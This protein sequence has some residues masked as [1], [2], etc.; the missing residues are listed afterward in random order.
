MCDGDP[1]GQ[2]DGDPESALVDTGEAYGLQEPRLSVTIDRGPAL[3]EGRI[4]L[5]A[6]RPQTRADLTAHR[7]DRLE[8]GR[9]GGEI[10]GQGCGDDRQVERHAV[11]KMA[12]IGRVAAGARR[13]Q[14]GLDAAPDGRTRSILMGSKD[15]TND[16]DASDAAAMRRKV[17]VASRE[18][19]A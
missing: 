10:G 15:G 6:S 14:A 16:L 18:E 11:G 19:I 1:V 17:W 5:R 2:I 12:R 7:G 13:S 8:A 4:G 9:S 3:F